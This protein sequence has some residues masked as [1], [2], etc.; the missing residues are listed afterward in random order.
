M[1]ALYSRAYLDYIAFD[2]MIIPFERYFYKLEHQRKEIAKLKF[3][4]K[5]FL[6]RA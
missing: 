4:E 3:H 5:D 1:R 6:F 2:D